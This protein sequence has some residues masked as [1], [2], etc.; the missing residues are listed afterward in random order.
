MIEV[1][2]TLV[3]NPWRTDRVSASVLARKIDAEQPTLLLDE[4]DATLGTRSEYGETVRGLLNSGFRSFPE[5]PEQRAL[6]YISS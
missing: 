6:E 1:L 3:R 5:G 2:E 4:T